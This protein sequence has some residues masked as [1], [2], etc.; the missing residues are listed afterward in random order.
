MSY[1]TASSTHRHGDEWVQV[2]CDGCG[3]LGPRVEVTLPR[4]RPFPERFY[5]LAKLVAGMVERLRPWRG[6]SGRRGRGMAVDDL[7]RSCAYN[8]LATRI[9]ARAGGPF[10]PPPPNTT[11]T[12]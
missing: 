7:C 6:P 3:A 8:A 2:K 1:L 11:E 5:K 10:G 4:R 12:A 9:I